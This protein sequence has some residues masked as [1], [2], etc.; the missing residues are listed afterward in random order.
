MSYAIPARRL[1]DE[2][3]LM[4]HLPTAITTDPRP[5]ARRG[6]WWW[7]GNTEEAGTFWHGYQSAWLP[8]SLLKTDERGR[9]AQA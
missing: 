9:F 4:Q 8:A 2:A 5:D 6:D 3:Y 1:W 7:T